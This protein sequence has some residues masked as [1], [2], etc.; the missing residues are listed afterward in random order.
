MSSSSGTPNVN[1]RRSD[2]IR[3]PSYR[4]RTTWQLPKMVSVAWDF[5]LG[6][7]VDFKKLTSLLRM[8]LPHLQQLGQIENELS[9]NLL[10]QLYIQNH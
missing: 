4:P 3:S 8:L 10:H 2:R 9:N 1:L 7:D 5:F 6:G